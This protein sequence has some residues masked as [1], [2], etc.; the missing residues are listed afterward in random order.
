MGQ[1]FLEISIYLENNNNYVILL[2]FDSRAIIR[3]IPFKYIINFFFDAA[4]HSNEINSLSFLLKERHRKVNET[5]QFFLTMFVLEQFSST[6]RIQLGIF[7]PMLSTKGTM[8]S[9]FCYLNI[10]STFLYCVVFIAQVQ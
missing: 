4:I 1:L 8:K 6:V 10:F 2:P 7:H 3:L 5:R 9:A